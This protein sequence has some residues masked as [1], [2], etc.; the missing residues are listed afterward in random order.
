MID[1]L[2]ELKRE[3]VHFRVELLCSKVL[4]NPCFESWS[5]AGKDIH[6]HYGDG[7]LL[8][9]TYEVAS[10]ADD[11]AD[12]HGYLQQD[13]SQINSRELF[14]SAIWHD[15]GKLWD[16]QKVN[17][18]WA[19]HD[20]HAREIHHISRSAMEFASWYDQ[21]K[22]DGEDLSG[23]NKNN[24]VHNILSHHGQRE[25]GSPVSPHTREAWILHLA[26]MLSARLDDCNK[27]DRF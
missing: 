6:H 19:K 11:I 20:N 7:G 12:S 27:H 15:Y 9:H 18:V 21:L 8:K 2:Q 22:N 25:W 16:Y 24:V 17:G 4:G 23:V 13:R 5:G 3:A 26:D 1:Y 10:F 14:V